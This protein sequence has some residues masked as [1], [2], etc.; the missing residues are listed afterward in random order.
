MHGRGTNKGRTR[1][2]RIALGITAA[3][4]L[5]GV[6]LFATAAE[7]EEVQ[8]GRI[9]TSQLLPD[10]V[11]PPPPRVDYQRL[12]ERIARLMQ[13]PDMV[14]LAVGTIERGHVRFLRGYG[15]TL[16]G[17]G[18]PVTPSTVFR[19]ASVSKGIASALVTKLA[20]DGRLS[21]EA[22]LMTM[23]T[24]L[25]LPGD[26]R[27]VT[28][29]NLLAHQVG[30]VSNAWDKRLEAGEDPRHLRSTLGTLPPLC[31]P[32]T[33]YAYQNIAY[34]A[35]AEIVAGVTGQDYAA[36]A[37]ARLFT[38]LGMADSSIG[39]AGL[40][41]APSWARP[42]HLAKVPA[43][44]NDS[45]YRIPAAGGVNSSIRDLVRWMNA[46]MGGAPTTLSPIALDAMHRPRVPTPPRGR[47]GPMDRALTNASYGLGWRSFDYAGH[48][49][50]G[51]RGSVDGYGSLVL[52]DPADKSGIALLWNSNRHTA[53]RLQLEF[54]D[55]LYG[56]PA[57]DWLD[58]PAPSSQRSAV[59]A[60]GTHG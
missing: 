22:P 4:A 17:S 8:G 60:R 3:A 11:R 49:L 51:H 14:G 5:A 24:S 9:A 10:A 46:Q 7:Q 59:G 25:T 33:C 56:L 55:M 16:S 2:R 34:D 19:W 58:L 18:D 23:R 32:G 48:H 29:A 31:P 39:R 43:T 28:V 40:Q 38:P 45:Y 26:A 15:E 6:S 30:L 1:S 27:R 20:E 53:A 35:A 21:L 13:E 37:Q 47:R 36:V 42:H 12:N 50:V 52:F 41:A 57:T 44:V 54:F